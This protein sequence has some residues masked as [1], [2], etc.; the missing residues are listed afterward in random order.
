M[1]QT[2]GVSGEDR[3]QD[4]DGLV[5]AAFVG[6]KTVYYLSQ[7]ASFYERP[8][9]QPAPFES[10]F[11]L[12]IV[13]PTPVENVFADQDD[14]GYVPKGEQAQISVFT[15]PFQGEGELRFFNKYHTLPFFICT[16]SNHR[17]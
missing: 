16:K 1:C 6:P 15:N 4:I 8:F 9:T 2:N 5:P 12:V 10:H 14:T 11:C 3:W 17:R 13:D 7:S